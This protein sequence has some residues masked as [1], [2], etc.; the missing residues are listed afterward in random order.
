MADKHFT[1]ERAGLIKAMRFFDDQITEKE[2]AIQ[3]MLMEIAESEMRRNVVSDDL[4][5]GTLRTIE[6]IN[7]S[8]IRIERENMERENAILEAKQQELERIETDLLKEKERLDEKRK[9]RR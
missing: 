2:H 4:E 8:D 3:Q 9:R 7:I 5:E 6:V 1:K